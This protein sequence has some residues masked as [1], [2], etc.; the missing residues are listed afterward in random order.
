MSQENITRM[1]QVSLSEPAWKIF[2]IKL[3]EIAEGY[4]K[5]S[6]K[7]KGEFLN[8]VETVHGGIVVTLADSAFGYA[9]NSLH[10][11]T[12]ASQLNIYFLNPTLAGDDLV[13]EARV[14]KAGKKTMM[15]EVSVNTLEGK[16]VAK[17]T[18]IG[19]PLDKQSG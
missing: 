4:A 2:G 14:V 18:G 13:A 6:L 3:E 11:P 9:L 16:L 17:L 5:L 1:R 15:A 19:I 10:F 12:V 7:T 8:F